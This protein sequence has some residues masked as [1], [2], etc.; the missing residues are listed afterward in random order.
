MLFDIK[1]NIDIIHQFKL[2]EL[3]DNLKQNDSV[4]K[5][6]LNSKQLY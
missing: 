5:I 6:D 3:I 2:F 4:N 1:K